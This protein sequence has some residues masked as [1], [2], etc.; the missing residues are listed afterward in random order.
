MTLPKI[1]LPQALCICRNPDCAIPYG[2]CHCGC[3]NIT[4]IAK[5]TTGRLGHVKGMPLAYYKCHQLRKVHLPE[6]ATPFK[7]DSIYCRLIPLTQGLH[8]IVDESDYIWLMKYAWRAV[9]YKGNQCFYTAILYVSGEAIY[10]GSSKDPLKAAKLYRD[11]AIK[12]FG[13]FARLG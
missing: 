13:E 5:R 12:Y 3:G 9:W 1:T 7:I 2:A 10:L 8:A 4:K 11:G 6:D